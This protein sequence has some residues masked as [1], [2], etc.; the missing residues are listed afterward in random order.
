MQAGVCTKSAA[1]CPA[2]G[3]RPL[4]KFNYRT[5][6]T[7]QVKSS[8]VAFNK[9]VSIH[10]HCNRIRLRYLKFVQD[11]MCIVKHAVKVYKVQSLSL[12]T[13]RLGL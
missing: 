12:F 13:G 3:G 1:K 6:G 8:Q 4:F 5:T 9:Q 10:A 7:F 11:V 2:A